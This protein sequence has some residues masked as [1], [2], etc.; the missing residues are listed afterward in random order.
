MSAQNALPAILIDN[1]FLLSEAEFYGKCLMKAATAGIKAAIAAY[2]C[3]IIN[4]TKPTHREQIDF[5][6]AMSHAKS[7][8]YLPGFAKT[9]EPLQG[10]SDRY[11]QF[12]DQI[13]RVVAEMAIGQ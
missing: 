8:G 3:H 1:T 9:V 11:A 7:E 2:G 6:R 10:Y 4:K 5:Y 12:E 13:A